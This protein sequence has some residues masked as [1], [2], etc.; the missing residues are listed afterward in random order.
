M[1]D[2][3]KIGGVTGWLRAAGLA[4]TACLPLSS[5]IFP[6]FSAHL[7]AVSPTCHWLEYLDVAS[8]VLQ[9][10]V[11]VKDGH[12]LIPDAPGAGLEWDQDAVRRLSGS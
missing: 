9:E 5:H 4:E 6:E 1:P 10:P 8:A 11:T 3:M 2:V 7:L 12:V